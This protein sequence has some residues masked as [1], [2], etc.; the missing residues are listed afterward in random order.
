MYIA[1]V[2]SSLW[3]SATTAL[4]APNAATAPVS[5]PTAQPNGS[6]EAADPTGSTNPFQTLSPDTQ[7]W[8]TQN[9]QAGGAHP[10]HH[11][12]HEAGTSDQQ[13]ADQTAAT[14]GADPV[15]TG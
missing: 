5:T 4:G 8:L 7:A 6:S 3:S 1:S 10:H 15:A 14:T 11:H 12:H 9:Q 13:L 2:A